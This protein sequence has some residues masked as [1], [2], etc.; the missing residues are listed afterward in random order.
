MSPL[1]RSRTSAPKP[2]IYSKRG[3]AGTLR[4]V[5]RPVSRMP[6]MTQGARLQADHERLL[7]DNVLSLCEPLSE[8]LHMLEAC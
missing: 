2:A 4:V 8:P 7:F 5:T 1:S 3:T 6:E